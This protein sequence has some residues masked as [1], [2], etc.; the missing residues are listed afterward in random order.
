MG[1]TPKQKK[2]FDYLVDFERKHGFMPSQHEIA[3]KFGYRSLGTVQ[4]YLVRLEQQGLLTKDWNARR[5]L[6][7]VQATSSTDLASTPR[8][9]TTLDSTTTRLGSTP[10]TAASRSAKIAELASSTARLQASGSATRSDR[11]GSSSSSPASPLFTLPLLGRV[12]AGRPIEA[13]ESG[14]EEVEVPSSFLGKSGGTF[15]LKVIGDSMIGDGILEGDL[16]IVNKSK[17]AM[18]GQTVVALLNN[19]ATVKRFYRKGNRVE[20]HAANPKYAPIIVESLVDTEFFRIEG[21]VVGVLRH[22]N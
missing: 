18:N 22:L 9:G 10:G 13:V 20:L 4:N 17:T 1:L 16:L 21:V 15:V 5:G 12:A 7:L 3:K 11:L 8:P 2:L 14:H 6:R 19:E